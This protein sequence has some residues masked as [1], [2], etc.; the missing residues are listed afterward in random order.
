MPIDPANF[1]GDLWLDVIVDGEQLTPRERIASVPYAVEAGTL[2]NGATTRGALGLGG[3]LN[4]LTHDITNVNDLS[5]GDSD[6]NFVLTNGYGNIRLS[7]AGHLFF[8]VDTDN[9]TTD[10]VFK[11]LKD[12]GSINPPV[13]TVFQVAE[14][15]E[16]TAY[17]N[18]DMNG[19]SVTNTRNVLGE[20][21][22]KIHMAAPGDDIFM[23]WG[24]GD[25]V[26]FGGGDTTADVS[27]RPTGI[28]MH[29]NSVTN[30][31]AL[32]EANLQTLDE[33]AAERIDRFD[34]GDV[35]CWGIDQLEKCV[36]AND[37]L[38]QAVADKSGRPI[39]IGAELVKALGP[40]K[41]GDILVASPVPG[42][43]MVNNDPI[44]GSVI[45]QAL[46]DFDGVQGIIKAMI[47]KW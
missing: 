21:T 2:P 4:L 30:C 19:R 6:A 8:F 18:L 17:G 43:A 20:G 29:G 14:S 12:A 34:E 7:S 25:S 38:V 15:G 45:A 22:Q 46:E 42:Y 28:N 47:R 10:A 32:V 13:A 27:I 36:T 41:R 23:N 40:V 33:L 11:V 5:A 1:T 16:I 37:R 24:S 39:V 9:D 44:S 26:F 31:G 35:L 3:D